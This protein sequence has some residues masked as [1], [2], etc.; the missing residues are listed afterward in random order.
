MI[1]I[2][3]NPIPYLGFLPVNWYGITMALGF[4]V[5]GYLTWRAAPRYN[6]PEV[7]FGM[8]N[9]QLTALAILAVAVPVFAWLFLRGGARREQTV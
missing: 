7:A 9:G 4:L 1:E 3:W 6:V 2:N 8:K 5:G